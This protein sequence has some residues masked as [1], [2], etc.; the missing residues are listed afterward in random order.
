MVEYEYSYPYFINETAEEHLWL[1]CSPPREP[2]GAE[3]RINARFICS[4]L[5]IVIYVLF[6]F[7]LGKITDT[8]SFTEHTV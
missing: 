2:A 4:C 6:F 1:S 7:P 8:V 3:I 5:K